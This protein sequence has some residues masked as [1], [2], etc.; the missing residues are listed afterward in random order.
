MAG[1]DISF[2]A[3]L[4]AGDEG[5]LSRLFAP[6]PPLTTSAFLAGVSPLLAMARM[7]NVIGRENGQVRP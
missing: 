4:G 3:F 5:L 2:F 6:L 7:L 1:D